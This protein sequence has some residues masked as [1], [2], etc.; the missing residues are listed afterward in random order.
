MA[1]NSQDES[2][3]TA[4]VSKA[5]VGQSQSANT[6]VAPPNANALP[7]GAGHNTAGGRV[8]EAGVFDAIRSIKLSELTEVH[9]KPCVRESFLTGI[10]GGFGIGAARAIWGG[11]IARILDCGRVADNHQA[12]VW[13]A[14]NWA[15]VSFVFGSA[16]MHEFCQRRRQLEM[17]GMKRAVEVIDR[18]QAEKQKMAEDI[19]AARRKAK[20]EEEARGR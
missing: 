9:K 10:G 19:K 13:S 17:Q 16:L 8:K 11:K 5:S 4:H 20:E 14:C 6:P 7:A 1:A 18:K 12:T 2:S 3:S 15:V